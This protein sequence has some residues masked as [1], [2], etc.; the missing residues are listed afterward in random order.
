MKVVFVH[1]ELFLPF[2]SLNWFSAL[3]KVKEEKKHM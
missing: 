2:E 3:L 1:I